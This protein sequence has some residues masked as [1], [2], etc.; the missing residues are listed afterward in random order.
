MYIAK[1][2]KHALTFGAGITQ[3]TIEKGGI[4]TKDLASN[5]F[6]TNSGRLL[7]LDIFKSL[8]LRR[9]TLKYNYAI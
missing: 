6:G 5:T 1:Y 9:T 2:Y 4:V 3:K 8:P 7:S